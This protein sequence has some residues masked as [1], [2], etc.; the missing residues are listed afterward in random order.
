MNKW[1]SGKSLTKHYCLEKKTFTAKIQVAI[2]QKEF[3][4]ILK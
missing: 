2:M 3:V 4:K 1:M